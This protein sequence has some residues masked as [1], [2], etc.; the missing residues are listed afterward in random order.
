MYKEIP[1]KLLYSCQPCTTYRR[2]SDRL[3]S[4]APCDQREII[5]TDP[6]T[7]VWADL[8]G[9]PYQ[10]SRFSTRIEI[11]L[12]VVNDEEAWYTGLGRQQY[13]QGEHFYV[14]WENGI[15]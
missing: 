10:E 13:H 1:R 9:G 14:N 7:F 15:H 2:E 6:P 4:S 11:S 8:S 3:N 12:P 5:R